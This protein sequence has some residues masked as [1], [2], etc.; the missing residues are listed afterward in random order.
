LDITGSTGFQHFSGNT[1][2]HGD[3]T[4]T[5][6][7]SPDFSITGNTTLAGATTIDVGSGAITLD[8]TV[9]GAGNDLALNTSGLAHVTGDM[10]GVGAFSTDTAL[11]AMGTTQLDGI[12]TAA[13]ITFFDSADLR[14]ATYTA[15]TGSQFYGRNVTNNGAGNISFITSAADQLI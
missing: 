7:G 2:L 12:L 3:Y 11:T 4:I 10:T 6:L 5:S 13:S 8:G 9:T 15:T 1:T 14:G